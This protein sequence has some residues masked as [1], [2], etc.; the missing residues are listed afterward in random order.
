MRIISSSSG[1]NHTE[2]WASESNYIHEAGTNATGTHIP[3]IPSS[4]D[5]IRSARI[6]LVING[7][8]ILTEIYRRIV[9]SVPIRHPLAFVEDEPETPNPRNT[10]PSHYGYKHATPILSIHEGSDIHDTTIP[11]ITRANA[12]LPNNESI[13]KSLI[14]DVL[15]QLECQALGTVQ[16]E[17]DEMV[18]MR[19][20]NVQC[21]MAFI[22]P[23]SMSS[24]AQICVIIGY[25]KW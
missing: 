7:H 6:R 17:R 16:S 23:I 20:D 3:R 8:E 15:S 18:S 12:T 22:R 10:V 2:A 1:T 21:A 24:N 13:A 11:R 5:D 19:R 14:L 4:P 25:R 9:L